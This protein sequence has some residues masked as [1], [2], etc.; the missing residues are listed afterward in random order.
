ML[1]LWRLNFIR[2]GWVGVGAYQQRQSNGEC[3]GQRRCSVTGGK[4]SKQ[5]MILYSLQ[6]PNRNSSCSSSTLN[7]QVKTEFLILTLTHIEHTQFNSLQIFIIIIATTSHQP[8]MLA[9]TCVFASTIY[10]LHAGSIS[11]NSCYRAPRQSLCRLVSHIFKGTEAS[12]NPLA[13]AAFFRP[14]L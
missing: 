3:H 14:S 12:T 6:K 1:S 2:H 11:L 4:F 5:F 9:Y 10:I 8:C 13:T 7:K